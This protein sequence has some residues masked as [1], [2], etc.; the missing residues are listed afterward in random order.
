MTDSHT[1]LNHPELLSDLVEVLTRAEAAGVVQMLVPGYDLASSRKA[2]E[3][4]EQFP[5][6]W[7][8]V[9]VHPHDAKDLDEAGLDELRALAASPRV[10]A[11]G[12]IGL[13]F[14]YDNSPRPVQKDAFARQIALAHE[15]HLPIIIHQR[16]AETEAM[17]IFASENAGKLGG[18]WHCFSGSQNLVEFALEHDF[19]IGIAGPVTFKKAMALQ[20][21]AAQLPA[22]NLLLETDAPY[23][24]PTPY[25][26]KR[27]EP[28][29]V[30]L[31]AKKIAEVRGVSLADIEAVTTA[32]FARLFLNTR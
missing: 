6:L 26:G 14:Y 2:V 15:L 1:H 13:D 20:E 32:N 5:S 28:A 30:A 12:E 25:R 24:T 27:N 17:E 3:L 18:V 16:D 19:F 8:S 7:A 21:L 11:I 10:V 23:L 9:G 4:A 31:V 29:Y 22:K